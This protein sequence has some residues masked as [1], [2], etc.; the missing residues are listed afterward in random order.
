MRDFK[1]QYCG[2]YVPIE[3]CWD[4]TGKYYEYVTHTDDG[5]IAADELWDSPF[6]C[7]GSRAS[8]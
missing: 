6:T 1:C 8:W 2:N 3:V 5:S 4:S 7:Q